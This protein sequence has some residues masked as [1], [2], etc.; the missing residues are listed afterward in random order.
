MFACEQSQEEVDFDDIVKSS[1]NYKEGAETK[2]KENDSLMK[3]TYPTDISKLFEILEVDYSKIKQ[4]EGLD[5]LDRFEDIESYKFSFH[6][7]EPQKTVKYWAFK[8][9]TVTKNVF[10]NW[11]DHNELELYA[12]K[13][14]KENS[15]S[16]IVIGNEILMLNISFSPALKSWIE[17]LKTEE[18]QVLY[19][20][21]QKETGDCVWYDKNLNE[22]NDKVSK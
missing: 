20:V 1:D 9:S 11:I 6:Y 19:L 14:L 13:R 7:L 18:K 2:E 21:T 22:K 16:L 10:Y 15:F 3:L 12:E 8:D 17:D 5:F 4:I